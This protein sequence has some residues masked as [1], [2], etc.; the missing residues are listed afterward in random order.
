M[1]LWADGYDYY[2]TAH[3][4]AI[5]EEVESGASIV[6]GGRCGGNRLRI[7]NQPA[8]AGVVK[9]I[10]A[11]TDT[12]IISAAINRVSGSSQPKIWVISVAG[13]P[14]HDIT[15]NNDGSLL[16]RSNPDA[17]FPPVSWTSP[18]GLFSSNVTRYLE[19]KIK[20]G[21]SSTGRVQIRVDGSITD[22]YDS[23][24]VSTTSSG[25]G[26][27]ATGISF[28]GGAFSSGGLVYYDDV[29]IMDT[30]GSECNDF[31]GDVRLEALEPTAVGNKSQ[32]TNT[33]GA[34]NAASVD[35]GTTP[36]DDSTYVEANTVNLIDT[37]I[38][39]D[40][41]LPTSGVVHAVLVKMLAKKSQ[42]GDRTIA[43]VTRQGGTDYV[44]DDQSVVQ[45]SYFYEYQVWQTN[46]AT[47]AAWTITEVNDAE[48]GIKLTA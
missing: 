45:D 11:T 39:E 35:D 32:W 25:D 7:Q 27:I 12:L 10:A 15:L 21:P 42:P 22:D 17:A 3:L 18:G 26:T 13:T 43:A 47:S 48:Y 1:I 31:L 34:N 37:N 8:F 5:Y 23:G 6:T 2:N 46:P 28:G 36:D 40:S 24:G 41:A 14:V 19:I 20:L 30:S 38:H 16:G 33:G 4:T 9:G 44:G 29:V